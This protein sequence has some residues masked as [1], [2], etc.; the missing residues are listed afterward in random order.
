MDSTSHDPKSGGE[1]GKTESLPEI[2]IRLIDKA[3]SVFAM[4]MIPALVVSTCRTLYTGWKPLYDLQIGIVVALGLVTP[5]RRRLGTE[6]KIWVVLICCLALAIGGMLQFGLLSASGVIFST[7]CV[8]ATLLLSHRAG[9]WFLALAALATVATIAIVEDTLA[10]YTFNVLT[11]LRHPLSWL[12]EAI[13]LLLF[14]GVTVAVLGVTRR[15][16]VHA[17]ESLANRNAELEQAYAKLS[18]EMAEHERLEDEETRFYRDTIASVTGGRLRLVDKA[19]T[20]EM[21]RSAEV[22]RT[23][24]DAESVAVA[25]KEVKAF[26]AAKG[27]PGDDLDLFM[28]GVGEAMANAVKHAGGGEVCM[29]STN[30]SVWVGASDKGPGIPTFALPSVAFRRGYSTKSSMGMGYSI[31]LDAADQITLSTGPEGTVVILTKLIGEE[32]PCLSLDDLPDT[33]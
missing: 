2:R 16:L 19:E 28:G 27:L 12:G 11:Y 6:T 5:L 25:R 21:L 20:A 26:C 17:L 4:L 7:A 30:G 8:L 9:M 10:T 22:R 32:K 14:T 33:W 15:T 18:T 31:I 29:Y 1:N 24:T 13:A 23:L 3:L